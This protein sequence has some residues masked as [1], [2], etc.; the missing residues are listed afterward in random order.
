MRRKKTILAL[1]A[2]FLVNVLLILLFQTLPAAK[3]AVYRRGSTGSGVTELQEKLQGW[4]Y[5]SG[6]AD[7]IY[8]S[9]TEAAVKS[10]QRKNGLSVDGV[11]GPATLAA[12]GIS[13]DG[14]ASARGND[15]ALLARLISAEARGE[16]YVGQVAVG[17]VVLNRVEHPSFPGTLSGVIYQSGAF[18]CLQ[19]GQ[20]DQPVSDSAYS[21][22]RDALNGWD[23]TGGAIYYFNPATATSSWIWSRPLIITIGKHR[24][25]A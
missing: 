15:T 1:C 2:V 18:S 5:Y 9:R 20:W 21:A 10:F 17:A 13:G 23:P 14:G 4:G 8:G 7:G 16:P 6:E 3:A 25:C 11:A 24:F 22:A 19:D 12:M